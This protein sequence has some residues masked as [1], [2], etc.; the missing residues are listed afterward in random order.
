M[1]PMPKKPSTV[2]MIEVCSAVDRTISP[3]KA[4]APVLKMAIAMP[5]SAINTQKKRNDVP[6]RNRNDA[7]ANSIKPTRI[8]VFRPNRSAR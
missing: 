8:V 3:I 7:A 5:D 6:A 2:F 1:E 4:S